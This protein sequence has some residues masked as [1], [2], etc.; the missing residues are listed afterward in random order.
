MNLVWNDPEV[1]PVPP[2]KLPTLH[3]FANMGIVSARTGWGGNDAL[4]AVKC[5][6]PVGKFAVENFYDLVSQG[7]MG[8]VHPDAGH[9]AIFG[10]GDWLIR[11]PGY[12]P[13]VTDSENELTIDGKPQRGQIKSY[14]SLWPLPHGPDQPH[15]VSA[16]STPDLDTIVVDATAAYEPAQGL[17]RYVRHILFMKPNAVVVA[18]DIQLARPHQLDLLF[19]PEA[20]PTELS[21]NV[22][23]CSGD[24]S[25]LRIEQLTPGEIPLAQSVFSLAGRHPG[26]AKL[27]MPTLTAEMKSATWRNVMAFSWSAKGQTPG[28]VE[29]QQTG[30]QWRVNVDGRE[31]TIDW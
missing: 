3:E 18:D 16:N 29:L 5:G 12:V 4:V 24:N 15:V 27:T 14:F 6:P 20:T 21:E 23:Q 19:H 11:D 17:G 7:D 31:A 22:F 1:V 25:E 9:F 30:N 28:K 8:H 2:D 10:E 26:D 13:R